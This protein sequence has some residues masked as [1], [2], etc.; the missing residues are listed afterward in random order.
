MSSFPEVSHVSRDRLRSSRRCLQVTV[1]RESRL[2]CDCEP[3]R[4]KRRPGSER[5]SGCMSASRRTQTVKKDLYL[6]TTRWSLLAEN[7]STLFF[8]ATCEGFM[9]KH[10]HASMGAWISCSPQ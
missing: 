2:S 8:K 1:V 4:E 10:A 9:T 3:T 5:S 6:M 7:C